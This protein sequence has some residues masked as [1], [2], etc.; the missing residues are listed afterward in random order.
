MSDQSVHSKSHPERGRLSTTERTIAGTA[1]A[2]VLVIALALAVMPPEHRVALQQCPNAA[3]GCIVTVDNDLTTLAVALSALGA[4]AAL[5]AI[6]GVRFNTVKAGGAELGRV[7]TDGLAYVPPP[8]EEGV[9][10]AGPP[11]TS[12]DEPSTD[13]PI[14]VK[15]QQGLG[16]TLGRAPIAVTHL[17][18]PMPSVDPLL[19]RDYRSARKKGQHGH[20][21]THILNPAKTPG[22]YSVV[23]RVTPDTGATEKVRSASFFFGKYW[24]N[25]VFEGRR[26]TDGRVGI[27]TE[28]YGPFLAL[29]EVQFESG[30]RIL[31][32]H[33]C[34]FD[35]AEL[36]H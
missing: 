36:L 18:E 35:M 24:G 26:G 5:I 20:F 13:Q 16:T 33:Y 11:Q 21:L 10:D 31:L 29:C 30:R 25:K 6:L 34:D 17:T 2:V 28:A 19:L 9:A 4:L 8:V 12:P 15:V 32:D 23:L 1:A 14:S 22:H 3:A 7:D 27:V